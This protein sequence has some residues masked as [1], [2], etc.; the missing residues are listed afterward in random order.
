MSLP[1]AAA[2]AVPP[3]PV[4]DATKVLL[5]GG[6]YYWLCGATGGV[7]TRPLVVGLTFSGHDAAWLE[8]VSWVTG[9]SDTTGWR[10]H[11]TGNGYTLIL[12][13]PVSGAWNAG[14][15]DNDPNPNGWPGSGQDDETF[16]L[17]CA[18]DVATRTPV[19]P[20][21]VFVAGG[22]AGGAMA[23]RVSIA[24]PDVFAACA[25]VAGWV[26]YRYPSQPWD[27]RI[28][29]GGQ[30]ATVPI[31]G[32]AGANGYVFPAAYEA[33]ARAPRGSR[34]PAYL[35]PAAGHEILGWWA[36]AA[37][38]FWTTERARP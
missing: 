28:D 15:G 35:V 22:S 3:A 21:R 20:A 12:P 26:P 1:R 34:V 7:T 33:M 29:H 25:M 8:S 17:N 10:R 11:A 23:A 38:G 27:C 16:L 4:P 31:R 5:P 18:A 13:E 9:H 14:K 36:G 19:D 30:D 2:A 24:H 32:G 6:R 37:W